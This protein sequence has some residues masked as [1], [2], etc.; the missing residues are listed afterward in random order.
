MP[1]DAL[2][3]IEFVAD[4]EFGLPDLAEVFQDEL[5]DYLEGEIRVMADDFAG[6]RANLP[7]DTGYLRRNTFA[8]LDVDAHSIG[9]DDEIVITVL[10]LA[11]YAPYVRGLVPALDSYTDRV[12]FPRWTDFIEGLSEAEGI[13]G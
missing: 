11:P 7:I 10:S 2:T 9:G 6:A 8:D 12:L 1:D 4:R 5:I 13:L 3:N